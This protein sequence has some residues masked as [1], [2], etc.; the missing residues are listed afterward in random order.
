MCL[1]ER[2]EK[3]QLASWG[4]RM[5]ESAWSPRTYRSFTCQSCRTSRRQAGWCLPGS[6]RRVDTE[7]GGLI[8]GEGHGAEGGKDHQI[9]LQEAAICDHRCRML[10]PS[11][12]SAALASC[13]AC[14][15]APHTSDIHHIYRDK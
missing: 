13:S 1:E 5:S 9:R 12:V 11:S 4:M 2:F 6:V 10:S 7:G 14:T 3:P 15:T 8:H